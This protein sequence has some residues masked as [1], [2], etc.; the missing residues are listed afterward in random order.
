[1]LDVSEDQLLV[2]LLVLQPEFEQRGELGVML[3]AREEGR[4]MMFDVR[5]VE[6]DRVERWP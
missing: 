3:G 4:E 5:A 6:T 1:M 2:L